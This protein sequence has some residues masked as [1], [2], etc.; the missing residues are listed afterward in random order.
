MSARPPKR[1]GLAA[2]LSV[3][4]PGVGQFYNRDWWRGVFWVVVT[5]AL[6]FFTQGQM[7]WLCHVGAAFTAFGRAERKNS[8]RRYRSGHYGEP[9]PDTE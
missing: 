7:G 8:R 1:P 6:W 5:P 4:L 3:I 9:D 2:L